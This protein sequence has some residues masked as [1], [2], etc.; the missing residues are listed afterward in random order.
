VSV[1]QSTRCCSS[2]PR[3]PPKVINHGVNAPGRDIR[4][5]G[6]AGFVHKR[7]LVIGYVHARTDIA[8]K[9]S[10]VVEVRNSDIHDPSEN[11]IASPQAVRHFERLVRVEARGIQ[12][13]TA[14]QVLGVNSFRP[15]DIQLL[16]Q[17]STGEV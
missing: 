11:T 3:S 16:A 4:D 9:L 5:G 7:R 12:V 15:A 8:G 2:I 10:M 1:C 13:E 17:R 14:R 6:S